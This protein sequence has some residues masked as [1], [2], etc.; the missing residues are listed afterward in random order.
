[1]VLPDDMGVLALAAWRILA[2]NLEQYQALLVGPGLGQE[3]TTEDFVWAL[4]T[5]GEIRSVRSLGFGSAEPAKRAVKLPPLV[6]DADALNLLA[7]RE[8][9][10]EALP[11][12]TVLTPHPGEMARLTR[13][14]VATI[15]ANRLDIARQYAMQWSCT[16]VLKGAFTVVAAPAGQVTVIP[17]ANPALSTAGTGDVLAGAIVGLRAQGLGGYV[18]GVCGAYLHAVAGELWRERFGSSGMLASDLLPLLPNALQ[19][20]ADVRP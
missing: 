16:V 8:R 14:D 2:D 9:W 17:F 18:A 7:R 15:N 3:A 6:L 11:S 4:I 5:G 20:L 13:L 19:R 1:V 12:D 10:W